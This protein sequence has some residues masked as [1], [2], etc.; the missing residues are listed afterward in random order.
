MSRHRKRARHYA[1]RDEHASPGLPKPQPRGLTDPAPTSLLD[2]LSDG[3]WLKLQAVSRRAGKPL[4]TAQLRALADVHRPGVVEVTLETL[5]E[6]G[7]FI[8]HAD[9]RWSAVPLASRADP[10]RRSG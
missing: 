6:H 2:G 7:Q 5:R 1:F 9:G 10:E 3:L 8:E 4:S